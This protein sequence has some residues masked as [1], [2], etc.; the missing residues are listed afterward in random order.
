MLPRRSENINKPSRF[1]KTICSCWG[2]KPSVM[3]QCWMRISLKVRCRWRCTAVITWVPLALWGFDVFALLWA[4]W[5][6]TPWVYVSLH[7]VPF[8]HFDKQ[9]QAFELLKTS[10]SL[11]WYRLINFLFHLCFL[12][13]KTM[14]TLTFNLFPTFPFLSLCSSLSASGRQQPT[15][16]LPEKTEV[17]YIEIG[18]HSFLV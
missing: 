1:S 18:L 12:F 10:T 16:Q 15:S 6:L 3:I 4:L 9:L 11:T 7:H 17:V 14:S 8:T 13:F 5:F 2:N